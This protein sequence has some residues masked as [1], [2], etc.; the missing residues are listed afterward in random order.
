MSSVR[1]TV[2]SVYKESPQWAGKVNAMKDDQVLAVYMRLKLMGL[3][4]I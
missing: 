3:I 2:K 4:K 1:N